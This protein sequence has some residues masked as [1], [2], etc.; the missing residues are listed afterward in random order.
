VREDLSTSQLMQGVVGSEFGLAG[1][2]NQLLALQQ[3]TRDIHYFTVP[4]SRFVEQVELTDDKLNSYYQQNLQRFMTPEQVAVEYVE[5][6]AAEL[7]KDIEVTPQQIAN[8]FQANQ[9]RFGS[10]EQRSVAHIMI[11]SEQD[12]ATLQQ[13]AEALLAELQAGADFAALA[14]AN[15]ADTFSAE[16]GGELGELVAGQMDPAFE[17]A[18]FALTEVGQLSPVVKSEFGYHIIK[19]SGYTPASVKTLDEVSAE[20]AT[21]LKAE[22]ATALFFDLQQRLAQ[23]AFEQPDNLEEA[24]EAIGAP[25]QSTAL[26]SRETAP[27]V[28]AVPTILTR[29]FNPNF[30]AEG[31][32]S[33]VMEVAREHVVVARI[34][35]HQ[36]ART[37]SLDEVRDIV[38][39][40]VQQEEVSKLTLQYVKATT[41]G[42]S[43]SRNH[44]K[45]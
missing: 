24:A 16:N 35:E 17:A 3:Q 18:A 39:A 8:Y 40:A 14:K 7:A 30:I 25:L 9:S 1:E 12:D 21:T 10:A 37:Q 13:K 43:R 45:C 34:K 19:L 15:S 28:L 38:Q 42:K 29:L 26:F 36:S 44:N 32:N 41:R 20:I 11:E 27:E 4:A 6:S 31:L 22:Q 5:L 23:L 2:I 33:D